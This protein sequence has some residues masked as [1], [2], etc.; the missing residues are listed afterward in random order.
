M[1][2]HLMKLHFN[3]KIIL[4]NLL[5]YKL[6]FALEILWDESMSDSSYIGHLLSSLVDRLA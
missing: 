6:L 2:R 5:F 1:M 3:K 4:K